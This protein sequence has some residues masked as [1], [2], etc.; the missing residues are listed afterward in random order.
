MWPRRPHGVPAGQVAAPAPLV[1]IENALPMATEHGTFSQATAEAIG[2]VPS[3]G[4]GKRNGDAA[5]GHEPHRNGTS[6]PP[7][8]APAPPD[9]A[10]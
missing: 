7:V 4:N 8:A 3:P 5:N 1:Q 9:D 6:V 10:A 2:A